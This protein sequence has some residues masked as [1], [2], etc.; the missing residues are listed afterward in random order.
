MLISIYVVSVISFYFV[1]RNDCI[2]YECSPMGIEL[3][4]MFIP[5][6]NTVLILAYLIAL[7]TENSSNILDK[8]FFIKRN[9]K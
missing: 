2:E 9:K 1:I 4:L 7:F 6:L 8:I 3:M 5:I